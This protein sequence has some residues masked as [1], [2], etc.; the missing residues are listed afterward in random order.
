MNIYKK[1]VQKMK[2]YKNIYQ[3]QLKKMKS[4]NKKYI[5]WKIYIIKR[6]KK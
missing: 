2:I 5:K 1:Q 6:N 3:K 4:Y